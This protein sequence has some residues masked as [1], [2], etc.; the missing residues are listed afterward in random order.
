MNEYIVI[1][2]E[3]GD[4]FMTVKIEKVSGSKL[5][6][7]IVLS[8]LTYW[9]FAQAFLNIGPKIQTTFDASPDIVNISVSLTSF[10]TG[11]FM[12]VAGN[13][14]DKFGKVKLTRIALV[15]SIVG[16]LMLIV[17]GNVVMLLLGRIVQGL[18]AA[19]IMPATISIVNDFLT[20]MIDKKHSVFGQSVHLVVL[21]YLPFLQEHW[22]HLF[23]G[24]LFLYYRSYYQS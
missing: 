19:I 18:S 17:S 11:V 9:L 1:N 3:I 7:G 22:L 5:L 4:V 14:S 21:G 2:I 20:V 8:I 16:S 23:F 15:L 13:I 6:T 24:S 10:V 12:V